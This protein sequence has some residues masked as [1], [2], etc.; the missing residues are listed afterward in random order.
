[1]IDKMINWCSSRRKGRGW[2]ALSSSSSWGEAADNITVENGGQMGGKDISRWERVGEYG[3][4][5][6]RSHLIW[7]AASHASTSPRRS[8]SV[9]GEP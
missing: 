4:L 9:D 7:M 8:Q 2:S 3:L 5:A 1:M 6:C